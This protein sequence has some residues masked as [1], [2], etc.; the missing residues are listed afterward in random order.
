VFLT[1]IIDIMQI[2]NQVQNFIAQNKIKEALD[3]LLNWA[4]ER[5][6]SELQ[7]NITAIQNRFHI[8]RQNNMRGIIDFSSFQKE[9]ALI[10]SNILECVQNISENH[11]I[12]EKIILF[13]ASNPS[14]TSKLQLEYEFRQ[15]SKEIQDGYGNLKLV[16]EWVVTA[17]TLQKAILDHRP[18]IIHFSGH[19]KSETKASNTGRDISFKNSD[20][21][22]GIILQDSN[23]NAKLVGIDAIEELFKTITQLKGLK[24]EAVIL[25]ACHQEFQAKAIARYVPYVIGTNDAIEDALAI[26][27]STGFYRGI[28]AKNSDINFAFNLAKANLKLEGLSGSNIPV[29]YIRNQ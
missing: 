16:S 25:N 13:L 23:G 29:L 6:E 11:D 5:N 24:I 9:Q 21:E 28:A 2:L 7:A 14:N 20:S 18:S 27:F 12:K 19:G 3:I 15:I 17:A 8:L 4:V 22:S 1:K 10:I 26:E